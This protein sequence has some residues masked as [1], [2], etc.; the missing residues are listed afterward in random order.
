MIMSAIRAAMSEGGRTGYLSAPV[1]GEVE[2]QL[3]TLKEQLVR[4]ILEKVRDSALSSEILWAANEAAAL[5]WCT[6]CPVLILPLLLEEKVRRAMA[7]WEKQQQVKADV[8]KRHAT[9]GIGAPLLIAA[10]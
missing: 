9:L 6:V 5:A 2:A 7:K 3:D 4:P 8:F 10:A 1:R